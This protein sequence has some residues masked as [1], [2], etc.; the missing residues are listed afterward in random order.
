VIVDFAVALALGGDTLADVAV[1]RAEP[2]V[3]GLVACDPTVSRTIA[4]LAA[5]APAAVRAI[6]TAR[7]WARATAWELAGEHAPDHRADAKNP[8]V[9]DLDATLVTSHSEKENAAPT[10]KR[11]VGFHPLCA[12]VDHGQ[13]GTGEPL[14]TNAAPR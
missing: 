11:G 5:D 7:A 9:L 10:F 13:P 12:F 2:G 14:A 3:Y 8:V 1:L 4:A 6:N